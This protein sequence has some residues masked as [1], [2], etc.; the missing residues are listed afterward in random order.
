[1]RWTAAGQ[2]EFMGRTDEQVKIRGYRIELGEVS[3][4]LLTH[5]DI[6]QAVVSLASH[7]GRPYLLAYLVPEGSRDAPSIEALREF[8]SGLLPDY[9]LPSAVQVL[10]SLPLMPSGKVD[11]RALP[12]PEHGPSPT[13]GYVPPST[14]MERQLAEVWAGVLGVQQVGVHDNFFELGGDSILSIQVVSRARQ[15]G[16]RLTSKDIFLH[17]SIA[18]LAPLV[19]DLDTGVQDAAPVEGPA[20]LTPVQHWFFSTYGELAHFT[21][22][23]VLELAEDPEENALRTAL[24]AVVAHHDAL[25]LRFESTEGQWRQQCRATVPSGV[26]T[27]RDLSALTEAQQQATMVE[28]ADAARA[29]LDLDAGRLIKAVLFTRPQQRAVLLLTVHHLA[30]DGVSWRILLH[31]LNTAYQQARSGCEV[32]LEP[33]GTAA[34]TWA[35]E[36]ADHTRSGALDGDLDYWMQVSRDA[37]VDLPVDRAGVHTAG[38][39][40]Q[41]TVRLGA[42]QTGALLYQVPGVYRTQINDVLLSALGRVLSGWTGR[43]RVLITLEG[44][45]REEILDGIDLSRTVGWFTSQFPVALTMSP[46]LEDPE[47]ADWRAV[48]TSVKEQL[49]ALPHRGLS[50]GALRELSAQDSPAVALRG[51]PQ[52]QIS[53]NYHG[54]WDPTA[55][56]D[57]LFQ[58]QGETLGTDLAPDQPTPHLVEVTG[59]VEAGE[60]ALTWLYSDQIHDEAT[61]R[62]L[63]E[64]MIGALR[65]IVEHCAEPGAGGRTPSD[66]PLAHL[67]QAGVDRLVGDGQSVEDIHP[68]TP[69]QAGI[70][71]HSLVDADSAAYVDQARLLLEGVSDPHALGAACQRVADRTPALRSA[72][73]WDGVDEP[74]QVVHRQLPVPT[75]YY[76][77]R[78]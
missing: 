40:R 28:A 18:A 46:G 59:V 60:L 34:L 41:V 45:G 17:Q 61:I 50:Y 32:T 23:T 49:R 31:D 42:A 57:G 51:D 67:D 55:A 43:E 62:R 26:L 22:S 4:A 33:T 19:G 16:L 8:A 12:A 78:A 54:Q 13:A 30:V 11:R 63:A 64:D 44:H 68:L 29:D 69:L 53:F 21:M 1:V 38:S 27:H 5:P 58:P 73:V 37:Q 48:L 52:P 7:E 77:W 56:A 10:P 15:A 14:P 47:D 9:M 71:F 65:G 75:T 72:L 35:H 25:R 2:L 3:S 76:D 70:L 6:T 20:P 39:T 36:L 74:L 66:F 24:E